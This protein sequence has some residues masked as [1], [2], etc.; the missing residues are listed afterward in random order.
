MDGRVAREMPASLH[1]LIAQADLLISERHFGTIDEDV[2]DVGF[3]VEW[4]AICH[5]HIAEFAYVK[6]A[7]PVG[8]AEDLGRRKRDRAQSFVVR[9]APG[10]GKSGLLREVSCV[11]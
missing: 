9:E 5:H 7:E 8:D 11:V 6:R 2:F 4:V 10:N 1:V 3:H